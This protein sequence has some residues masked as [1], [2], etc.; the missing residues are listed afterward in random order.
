[1]KNLRL[2]DAG[3]VDYADA[4]ARQV[5]VFD[6]ILERKRLAVRSDAHPADTDFSV[7]PVLSKLGT[8][9][10]DTEVGVL[11]LCE[12][13]HVY[14]LGKSG[15]INNLLVD[16]TFLERIGATY[17]KTDRGGDITYHGYGQLVG[18]PILD[19]EALGLSLRGYIEVLELAVIDVLAVWGIQAGVLDGATGVWIDG[20]RKICAIGVKAS[21]YVTMHGFALNV[22]TDLT[23][24]NH[25]NPCGFVDKGVTSMERELGSQ[26]DMQRVKSAFVEAVC[27]RLGVVVR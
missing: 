26:V 2:L 24:F 3:I 23:Y 6:G 27:G 18:Y 14:T 9:S 15:H 25:I 13:P 11:M 7:E 1:M 5:E 16:S 4:W 22:N 8:G 12:H 20:Q 10:S 17:F 21:R 19:I